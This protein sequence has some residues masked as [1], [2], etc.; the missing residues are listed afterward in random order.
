MDLTS[1]QT[2]L[3]LCIEL[4][5]LTIAALSEYQQKKKRESQLGYVIC[6]VGPHHTLVSCVSC[7]A[8]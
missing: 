6:R 3:L 5:F 2:L 4:L 7:Y 8:D 1:Y